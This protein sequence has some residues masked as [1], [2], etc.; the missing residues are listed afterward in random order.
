M[1][2]AIVTLW[3]KYKYPVKLKDTMSFHDAAMAISLAVH[4]KEGKTKFTGK[5]RH[6]II[7]MN[8]Y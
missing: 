6:I 7:F 8:V 1:K 2:K 5:P 4:K 3:G